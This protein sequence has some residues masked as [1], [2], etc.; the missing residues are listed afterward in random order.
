MGVA[1]ICGMQWRGGFETRP[2]R[3][4][5]QRLLDERAGPQLGKSLLQFGLRVHHDRP[6]PGDR[7]LDR[8][9]G[10]EEKADAL[11]AG[12]HRDLVATVEQNERAVAGLLARYDL[13]AA[14]GFFG[15]HAE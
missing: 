2:D 1:A 12:L 8:L 11:F 5:K 7:L 6:V 13:A 10:D 4:R 14:L 3:H 9:A 15:E